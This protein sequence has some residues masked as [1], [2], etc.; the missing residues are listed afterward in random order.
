MPTNQP[1]PKALCLQPD[2]ISGSPPAGAMVSRTRPRHTCPKGL[3]PL[4]SHTNPLPTHRLCL[5]PD[6][7][8]HMGPTLIANQING[9]QEWSVSLLPIF[10]AYPPPPFSQSPDSPLGPFRSSS[11]STCSQLL[12][13]CSQSQ[14]LSVAPIP[15]PTRAWRQAREPCLSHLGPGSPLHD[16]PGGSAGACASRAPRLHDNLVFAGSPAITDASLP[17]LLPPASAT[18]FAGHVA[19]RRGPGTIE[20]ALCVPRRALGNPS[21]SPPPPLAGRPAGRRATLSPQRWSSLWSALAASP[22]F[23]RVPCATVLLMANSRC[24]VWKAGV[25]GFATQQESGFVWGH[26]SRWVPL[27]AIG[28]G[29]G[30]GRARPVAAATPS[31][32]GLAR[33]GSGRGVPAARSHV[34]HACRLVCFPSISLSVH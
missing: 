23:C 21:P 9:S 19:R 34:C 5:T 3:T 2:R 13:R 12:S 7:L 1:I 30:T 25:G 16:Q 11:S 20:A 26:L 17:S 27:D 8:S 28:V 10:G 18:A 32:G 31:V 29:T 4:A 24:L 14:P 15:V 33:A 22:P 6:S